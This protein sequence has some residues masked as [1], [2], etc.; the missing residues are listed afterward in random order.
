VRRALLPL[1]AAAAL[2]ACRGETTPP[3]AQTAAQIEASADQII[4]GMRHKVTTEGVRK[5]DLRSDTAYTRPGDPIVRLKGVRLT[6]FDENGRQTGELTSKTGE[7]NLGAGMMIARGNAV[8]ALSGP[9]G[10]RVIET[11][12]LHYEQRA[13]RVWSEKATTMKEAGQTYRGN[14]FTSDTKFE[15]V[16]VQQLT[17]T[18]IPT[19]GQ[20]IRF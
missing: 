8:L 6:F 5:A 3:A 13:D 14:S 2:A 4:Y 11:E 19:K 9:K 12:E 1:A 18:G 17:T 16:T 15:N 10:P 7:Y 20:G